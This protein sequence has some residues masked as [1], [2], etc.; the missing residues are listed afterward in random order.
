MVCLENRKLL[1]S[2]IF[3]LNYAG[4]HLALNL[5]SKCS[6]FRLPQPLRCC[7]FNHL[8]KYPLRE[9]NIFSLETH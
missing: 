5:N 9:W 3:M 1:L 2:K 8:T 4:E 6:R 7:I